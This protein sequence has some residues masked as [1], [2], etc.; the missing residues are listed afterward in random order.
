MTD[1]N[2]SRFSLLGFLV[3][4]VTVGIG[5]AA[6]LLF[7]PLV[8]TYVGILA[9]G[10][11][12]GLATS[13]RPTIEAGVAAVL[14]SLGILV[15]GALPGNGVVAALLS[16]GSVDPVTLAISAALSFGVGA[17]GAHFGEDLRGGLT[18][19]VEESTGR[20]TTTVTGGSGVTATD[21]AESERDDADAADTADD[22][23]DESDS[24]ATDVEEITD[25][26]SD[27]E[28]A[29]EFELEGPE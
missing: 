24:P 29:T 3:A 11:V 17:F 25:R 22:R 16:L 27:D 28:E 13:T 21:S 18:E 2:S 14:A 9:G 4:L 6:G 8:G 10:F 23:S 1:S 7:V 15:A 12:A 19:P 5:A 20:P 26:R